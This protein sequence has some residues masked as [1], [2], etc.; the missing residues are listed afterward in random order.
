MH[1]NRKYSKY[2]DT[3]RL[4][5]VRQVING[6]KSGCQVA[7]QL[8]TCHSLI[9]RWVSKYKR[10]GES[11]FHLGKKF[12]SGEFKLEIVN[13]LKTNH[14]SLTQAALTFGIGDSVIHSWCRKFDQFGPNGLFIDRRGRRPE[15][16]TDKPRK[17]KI[18]KDP[19]DALLKELHLLRVENAYLKKLHALIQERIARE[20][21]NGQEPSKD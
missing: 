10:Y 6:E 17:P 12:Y 13:H 19:E 15:M 20:N 9:D 5:A 18:G 3:I 11:G 8:G 2:T 1:T 7:E 16:K 4:I 14:L 21:G